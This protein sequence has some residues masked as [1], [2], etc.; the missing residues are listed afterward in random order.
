MHRILCESDKPCVDHIDH[1]KLNN[2]KSNL[3]GCNHSENGHNRLVN[4]NKASSQYKGVFKSRERWRA[5]L[6][7]NGVSISGGCHDTEVEAAL[8]Y[9]SIAKHYCGD[10][11]KL[12]E[13]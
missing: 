8:A 1:D 12:N 6:K 4:K 3:R 7:I 13:I 5:R 11:A 10:F 2:R 9:N